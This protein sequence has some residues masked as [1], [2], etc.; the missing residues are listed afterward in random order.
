[1]VKIPQPTEEILN[2]FVYRRDALTLRQL[3]QLLPHFKLKDTKYALRRLREK[4]IITSESNLMD[5]RRVFYRL[6][7]ED[8]IAQAS[9]SIR[10]QEMDFYLSVIQKPI[11][12][13]EEEQFAQIVVGEA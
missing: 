7:T 13:M 8:E 6:A 2:V 3:Q 9:L 11:S 4:G 1:M 10:K 5:M 12:I